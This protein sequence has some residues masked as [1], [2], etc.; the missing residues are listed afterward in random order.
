[1]ERSFQKKQKKEVMKKQVGDP[2][3]PVS[4]AARNEKKQYRVQKNS[5]RRKRK[6]GISEVDGRKNYN[7]TTR[8]W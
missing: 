5:I 7:R 4:L 8:C 3:A 6:K 2:D 1:M